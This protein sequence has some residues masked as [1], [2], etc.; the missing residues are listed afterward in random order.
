MIAEKLK[1]SI[2]Q[3]AIQGR[4]VPQNP[5]DEPASVLLDKIRA[6]KRELVK[7]GKI[8][9]DK[10]ESVIFRG[11]DQIEGT[12][13]GRFYERIG[14]NEPVDI[15]ED[16]PFE[17]P[18]SWEWVRI[19]YYTKAINGKAF[20]PSDWTSCGLPIVRIQNLNDVNAKYN[21]YS[22]D[23]DPKFLINNGELLFA[24]SGTPG[25]SFGAHIW[26]KGKAILNQHIFRLEYA[27]S[28]FY[29][30]YY[31]FAINQ[32]VDKLIK[33]AHGAVGLQHITKS[34]FEDT[35][36]PL[37]P[38]VEQKRIIS[39]LDDLLPKVS[40]YQKIETKIH[41]VNISFPDKFRKSVLQAAVQGKLVPQN[42][43]DEP[44]S[45]LLQKVRKK[46]SALIK[47][48]KIKKPKN[49]SYIFRR[50][51]SWFE[52]T[53]KI[54]KCIDEEIPFKIPNNWAWE[55]LG[56]IGT[57]IRGS[58][59]KRSDITSEGVG[60][61]RYGEIYTTYNISFSEPKSFISP[62]L[63]KSLKQID[64]NDLLFTLTGENK[65]EIG[66]TIAYTGDSTIYAGG[67]LGIYKYHFLNPLY[68]SYI[69]NSPYGIFKKS[70]LGT[71]NII[72]HISCDKLANILI[73][74][75]PLCEQEIIV[76]RI[77]EL[78]DIIFKNNNI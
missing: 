66:K 70:K 22:G 37:P 36:I 63:S 23:V 73:P 61:I 54:E 29:K 21:F 12:V 60:C 6:E 38:I 27:K 69:F 78:S 45:V 2:L 1:K 47:S 75:S 26:K 20:K 65:E 32:R 17:I 59:I 42:P 48:G 40:E 67:D 5:D 9:A 35:F 30:Q 31:S 77:I 19:G 51:G 53:G 24:W 4:L 34:I 25:T 7:A 74:V 55:R 57:F 58:G 49:E 72:V 52:I 41:Q 64:T 46:R 15:T 56:N 3:E 10:Q 13:A 50:E 44:A 39:A 16:L 18:D 43:A 8:R 28:L 14:K 76:N 11:S 62:D 71:G 68:L 33:Q